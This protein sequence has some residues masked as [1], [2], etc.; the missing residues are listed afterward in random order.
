MTAFRVIF[1]AS[2]Y[3]ASVAFYRET[4]G[5]QVDRAWDRG[6]TQKG[7]IFVA[8]TGF[9]EVLAMDEA[10]EPPQGIEL[11]VPVADVDAFAEE[12]R[13]Q[14]IAL[15]S[16]LTDKPWGHRTVSVLD[17]DGVRVIAYSEIEPSL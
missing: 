5:L 15:Y 14:D 11:Y 4:L 3:E 9:V 12:L 10:H 8:G 6:P 7:T 16:E 1:R 2:D 13:A 17:P